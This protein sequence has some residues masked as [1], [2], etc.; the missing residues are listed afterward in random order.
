MNTGDPN[1]ILPIVFITNENLA[2]IVFR[3]FRN[4]LNIFCEFIPQ[5]LFMLCIFF[6]L[7]VLIFYKWVN[8]SAATAADAPSLLI[9]KFFV[10]ILNVVSQLLLDADISHAL[11][12]DQYYAHQNQC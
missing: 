4:P 2:W 5:L 12:W 3:Y 11:T 9:G 8:F 10:T 1:K 7:V 6:Y